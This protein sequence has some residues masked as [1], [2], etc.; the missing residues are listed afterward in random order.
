M[1]NLSLLNS[2][3]LPPLPWL[4]SKYAEHRVF[5]IWSSV[6]LGAQQCSKINILTT[7]I[8]N[9]LG[10]CNAY[11]LQKTVSD[12]SE[13]LGIENKW[14]INVKIF[15]FMCYYFLSFRYLLS[16]I[17]LRTSKCQNYHRPI[18]LICPKVATS[19]SIKSAKPE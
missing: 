6:D 12:F 18:N 19:L 4:N 8:Y 17:I 5:T 13:I 14:L 3:R 1:R 2:N 15:F 16:N 7:V 10:S 9:C 11:S